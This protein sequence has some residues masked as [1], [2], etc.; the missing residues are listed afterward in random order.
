MICYAIWRTSSIFTHSLFMG[1]WAH[2]PIYHDEELLQ[3]PSAGFYITLFGCLLTAIGGLLTLQKKSFYHHVG[4]GI[5]GIFMAMAF[6]HVYVNNTS[7]SI[8]KDPGFEFPSIGYWVFLCGCVF[9]LVGGLYA[10]IKLEILRSRSSKSQKAKSLFLS[11]FGAGSVFLLVFMTGM[12]L[13]FPYHGILFDYAVY[14]FNFKV[15]T[16]AVISI[17]ISLIWI[18]PFIVGIHYYRLK[19]KKCR[20]P[21]TRRH[22]VD[23]GIILV[24]CAIFF[25]VEGCVLIHC[26]IACDTIIIWRIPIET[27]IYGIA[28]FYLGAFFITLFR[29]MKNSTA[30]LT[31]K[32]VK[33]QRR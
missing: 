27:I 4:E 23:A 11:M 25:L 3:F 29:E 14:S 10:V 33:T 31:S 22:L 13:L 20:G 9:T 8:L 1:K 15:F 24:C 7:P 18:I 16:R 12:F 21:V 19:R 28:L 32:T 17:L 2:L 5:I 26:E 30:C 6:Y